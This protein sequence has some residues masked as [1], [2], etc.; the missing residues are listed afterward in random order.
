MLCHVFVFFLG[1]VYFG[2]TDVKFSS[3]CYTLYISN[4]A[5]DLV[6]YIFLHLL[7]FFPFVIPCQKGGDT[8]NL[9]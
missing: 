6:L 8:L 7:I 9:L 1:W 5:Y 2:C 4:G 3:L